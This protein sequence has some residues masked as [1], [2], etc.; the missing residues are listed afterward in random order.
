ML[1]F[2]VNFVGNLGHWGYLVIFLVVALECQAVLGLAMPGESLVLV[3]G[4]FAEQGTFDLA[5][6]VTVIS[7][8]AIIG[9]SLGYELGRH[10]GRAWLLKFGGR[11]GLRQEHLDRVD[12]FFLHHGGKAVFSSHFLHLFRSL[13]PFAAGSRR[14]PYL[15]FLT[16]NAMGCIVWAS[17]FAVLGYLAGKSWRIAAQW[18]GRAGEIVG[19][20]LLFVL[21]FGWLWRRLSRRGTVQR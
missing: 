6:L 21:V 20:V 17:L 9:D 3:G 8:A 12:K 11:F 1:D 5:V 2:L 15:K 13:M 18:V 19:V 4:F 16:F 10:L 14:V 7:L